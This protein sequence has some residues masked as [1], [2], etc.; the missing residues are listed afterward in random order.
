MPHF[1]SVDFRGEFPLAGLDFFHE[2]FPGDVH[3][4][5]FNP[6]IPLNDKD[7]GIPAAF[8]E[9]QVT[10]DTDQPIDYTLA[11]VLANPLSV[12]NLNT[13]SIE[14]W[15]H[16]LHLSSDGVE[17]DSVAFGDLTLATDATRT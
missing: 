1:H 2:A 12:N 5:A 13:V 4:S 7:S 14:D 6:F 17:P 9:F 16:Q 10:N 8:F 11:G 15:G 3:L